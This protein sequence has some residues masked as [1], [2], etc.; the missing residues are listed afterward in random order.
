[1]RLGYFGG[2]FDPPHLGHLAVARA[3]ADSFALDHVLLVPTAS[4]PL[5][6]DGAVAS[7]RDRLA[8]VSLLCRYDPRLEASNLEA[9]VT[10]PAPN[11]TIDT[12]TRL[13]AMQ[14]DAQ[15]FVIV[16]VDAFHEL[17]RWRAPDQLLS[18]A[19]WIVV[20]RPHLLNDG[21]Y[22]LKSASTP[23]LP[24]LTALQ[25]AHVHQL[26]AIDHPASATAVRR[27][28]ALGR[29]CDGLLA[30]EVFSYIRDH[31]LYLTPG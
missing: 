28:L 20:T 17:P 7:Y 27:D 22:P 12:L 23:R 29:P 3:A 24:P 15:L 16:G 9:P 8:M 31:H 4:Q 18:I 6:P 10:P 26:T 21:H 13:H 11:Y 30:S 2:S 5:K 1:M 25:R 14:P 19:D